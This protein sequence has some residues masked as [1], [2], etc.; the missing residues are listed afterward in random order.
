[1]IRLVVATN[2]QTLV[3]AIT[4]VTQW[5]MRQIYSQGICV[6]LELS[7]LAYTVTH[8][9]QGL[10]IHAYM[11]LSTLSILC[12]SSIPQLIKCINPSRY[13]CYECACQLDYA[14]QDSLLPLISFQ[15]LSTFEQCALTH[16][17]NSIMQPT[18]PPHTNMA[19]D[20]PVVNPYLI[21]SLFD[22]TFLPS[23]SCLK[24]LVIA[25]PNYVDINKFGL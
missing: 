18:S 3:G 25:A 22:F 19:F 9:S 11:D 2:S 14:N 20:L 12:L 1:M 17:L 21:C 4:K 6:C 5:S 8:A 13:T 15:C 10:D 23:S 24:Q 16:F 7:P